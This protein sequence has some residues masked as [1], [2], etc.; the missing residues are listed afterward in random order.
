MVFVPGGE[1]L[2]GRTH[3][4]PGADVED[5]LRFFPNALRDARPLRRITLDPFYLDEH[6]VTNRQYAAFLEATGNDAPY[7]WLNGQP[8]EGH[9]NHPV[10]NVTWEDA[11]AYCRWAGRRLPTEAE[12]ERACRGAAE[13][14]SYPWGDRDPTKDDA[15]FDVLDGPGAV[16][17]FPK[18]Y[19]GLCDMAGNVWEWTTDWYAKDYYEHAPAK[20]PPG[21]PI[22]MY[23][24]M[25]G[26][27]W[28]DAPKYLPC[29]H[30]TYA[31]PNTRSPNIGFRCA[32]NLPSKGRLP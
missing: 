16:C 14:A 9:E 30:R 31:R 15:R 27:S 13:G 18:N 32:K 2:R 21:P 11:T 8:P 7:Y 25:R 26:A 24:V 23:R 28:A 22:G 17:Q 3:K 29:G 4:L 10:V 1:F 19:F 12:W 6:E 20:N 5:G